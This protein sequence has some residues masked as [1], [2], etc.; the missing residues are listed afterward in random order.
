MW[1]CFLHAAESKY[2]D[3]IEMF[4]FWAE[5]GW[6]K[7][8]LLCLEVKAVSRYPNTGMSCP[9]QRIGKSWVFRFMDPSVSRAESNKVLFCVPGY[10]LI[11]PHPNPRNTRFGYVKHYCFCL[12]FM[13][14]YHGAQWLCIHSIKYAFVKF[15]YHS[16]F[17]ATIYQ[18]AT[19]CQ[20]LGIQRYWDRSLLLRNSEPQWGDRQTVY[21]R[22][23]VTRNVCIRY[24]IIT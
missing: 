5:Q 16:L 12:P 15:Q 19:V 9:F 18:T 22:I 8:R 11:N 21:I 3:V 17:S 10:L 20:A 14:G 13:P 1:M 6:W 7:E 23:N 4:W 2:I 24:F